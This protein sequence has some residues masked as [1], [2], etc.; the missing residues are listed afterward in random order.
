MQIPKWFRALRNA[1]VRPL[2]EAAY[3]SHFQPGQVKR[4]VVLRRLDAEHYLVRVER[5]Q[6][7]ARST[8]ALEP[9]TSLRALILATEPRLHLKLLKEGRRSE[10]I[11]AQPLIDPEISSE[12]AES[13][14][15]YF[16][17]SPEED[18]QVLRVSHFPRSRKGEKRRVLRASL[19]LDFDSVGRTVIDISAVEN[20]LSVVLHA[21]HPGWRTRMQQQAAALRKRLQRFAPQVTVMVRE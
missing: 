13:I 10:E 1:R 17:A 5:F 15:L 4:A 12:F 3:R 6:F 20:R 14:L 9:S 16:A 7:L 8:L 19:F 21:Q 11:V 2:S 18:R